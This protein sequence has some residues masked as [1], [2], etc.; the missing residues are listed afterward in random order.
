[1][2]LQNISNKILS[3]GLNEDNFSVKNGH[4]VKKIIENSTIPG[5]YVL[6][7]FDVKHLLTSIH[8]NLVIDSVKKKWNII[9]PHCNIPWEDMEEAI[10]LI[11][12]STYIQFDEKYY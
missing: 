1:M 11:I 9:A 2:V 3:K 12:K 5:D 6:L 8:L 4:E 10:V 7:S